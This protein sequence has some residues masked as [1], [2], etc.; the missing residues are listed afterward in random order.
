MNA[1]IGRSSCALALS[2]ALVTSNAAAQPPPPAAAARDVQALPSFSRLVESVKSA[3]VNVEVQSRVRGPS[4]SERPGSDL[5][6]QFFGRGVRP[7]E[8]EYRQG[9]GSGFIIDPRGLILTNNHVVEDAVIIRV[10]LDDA[11]N[12]DAQIAGRDPLT[13]VAVIRIKQKVDNLPT[14]KL[15]DSDAMKVGD[16]VVAI[17]NPLGLA[18]SVSAG[19]VSA[20][21][22]NVH[23]TAYDD[24]IQTDAAIN[25]GNS[26]GP[27]F[28]TRGEVIGM[29]TAM[30]ANGA[31]IG[32]AVP[33][34]M[35]KALVPQLEKNGKVVRGYLGVALQDLNPDLAQALRVPAK[36]G[37]IVIEVT[38]NSPATKVL[39]PDDVITEINGQK[40]ESSHALSR[41]VA[42]FKPGTEV[43]VKVYRAGQA[44][45]VKVALGT[46]PD[47]E[48]VFR[49]E[50]R[51]SSSEEDSQRQRLGLGIQDVDP[52]SAQGTEL[53]TQG[54]QVRDV[55]PGSP[56]ERAEL[57]RGMVIVEAA[58]KPVRSAR[59]LERVMKEAKPGSFLLL[60]VVDPEA[61]R[62]LRA[63][64]IPA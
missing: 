33:S 45:E 10:T 24:L 4:P 49:E 56:A 29:N 30:V 48:G 43:T 27:L 57:R 54:A 58:G 3:V 51:R 41:M 22:R 38:P 9:A 52:R 8:E 59:D 42:I 5:F 26:G 12:F 55:R 50:S 25:P 15:G 46:R 40:V 28:N 53:P 19:I 11:R 17:G 21:A 1:S 39:K 44:R 13:D 16:W 18:S 20:T 2:L 34:N 61:G 47:I 60:R 7:R 23:I 31:R 32:F 14:V 64:Q 6:E 37:A 63:L 62:M 35:I 36:R